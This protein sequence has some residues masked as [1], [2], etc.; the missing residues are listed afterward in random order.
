MNGGVATRLAPIAAWMLKSSSPEPTSPALTARR[1]QAAARAMCALHGID[2]ETRTIGRRL[3]GPALLVSNHLGYFD[4]IVIG[5]LTACVSV[6]KRELLSWPL[7]GRRLRDL[8][9][10]FV[11]RSN[12]WSG[13]RVIRTMLHAFARG[14]SVLNFSEGTTSDGRTVLPFRRGAFGA[15]RIARVPIVPVRIDYDDA[16]IA[17]YGDATFV[18][19]YLAVLSR[20]RIRAS[21]TFGEP[22]LP[23]PGDSA[24]ELADAVRCAIEDLP[25]P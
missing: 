19:H 21:V 2:A 20:G 24:R 13:A 6:A 25:P 14:A 3:G 5:G 16:R 1:Q 15:A 10:V 18:P 9:V 12:P 7:V 23:R 8:G 17:W 11:D 22:I 4:P